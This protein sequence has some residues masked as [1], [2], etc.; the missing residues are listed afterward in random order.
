[1]RRLTT[2]RGS[3]YRC[4]ADGWGCPAK[5][6]FAHQDGVHGV[7]GRWESGSCATAVH[8][9]GPIAGRPYPHRRRAFGWSARLDRP[10]R[11]RGNFGGPL[12]GALPRAGLRPPRWGSGK[13]P[14]PVYD[15]RA[16]HTRAVGEGKAVA[17]LPQSI[18]AG[19]SRAGGK[20]D[21]LFPGTRPLH[22]LRTSFGLPGYSVRSSWLESIRGFTPSETGGDEIFC[23]FV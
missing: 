5:A 12:P 2:S 13:Q 1:M 3:G 16:G 6:W 14:R 19:R 15:K 4:W 17:A 9:G 21:S 10:D 7:G 22:C 11:D 23:R 8:M 18:G 20:A